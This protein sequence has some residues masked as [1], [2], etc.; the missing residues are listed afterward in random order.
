M[1]GYTMTQ[2]EVIYSGPP[3]NYPAAGGSST[4]EVSAMVGATGVFSQ[5]YFPGGFWQQG[6]QNQVAR[7]T[8]ALAVTAQSSA[9]T[10]TVRLRMN[11]GPNSFT[12]GDALLAAYNA[13]TVT[14]YT[15]GSIVG[16]G[17]IQSRG[18]G[19][20]TTTVANS[21]LSSGSLDGFGNAL[22]VHGA[23]GPTA[24]T[25]TDF[26]VNQWLELS[27]QFSTNSATNAAT[28]EQFVLEGMN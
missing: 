18:Q 20:G 2:N 7:F 4:T 10:L 26:S 14:S 15:A 24:L 22:T 17:I 12:T 21:L 16:S 13:V 28:L 27:V 1:S 11:T 6:R 3:A 5:P 23:A 8:F 25:T 19:Y 9:T